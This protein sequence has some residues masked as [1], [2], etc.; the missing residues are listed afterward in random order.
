MIGFSFSYRIS[1]QLEKFLWWKWLIPKAP[2]LHQFHQFPDKYMCGPSCFKNSG[3]QSG[4]NFPDQHYSNIPDQ[5]FKSWSTKYL[6]LIIKAK[7]D[8]FMTFS[9]Q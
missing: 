3:S 5:E 1:T 6:N 7:V 8:T 9:N 4:K 2:V